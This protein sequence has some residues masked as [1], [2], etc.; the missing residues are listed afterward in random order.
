M[1]NRFVLKNVKVDGREI[2]FDYK[3]E[4]DWSKVFGENKLKIYYS[5][6]V[7]GCSYDVA[8]IPL[9]SNILP[10]VWLYDAEVELNEIDNDFYECLND[11]KKGY[12]RMYP[13]LKFGGEI[14]AKK[15]IVNNKKN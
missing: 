8:C 7:E 10:L 1:N 14:K 2:Y 12:E 11:V 6:S 5:E 13:M 15:I 9:L 3:V 4:G